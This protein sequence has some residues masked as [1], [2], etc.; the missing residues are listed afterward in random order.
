MTS[1]SSARTRRRVHV[2]HDRGGLLRSQP[3][4]LRSSSPTSPARAIAKFFGVWNCSQ[5]R[6]WAKA[7]TCSVS[8][9]TED[10]DFPTDGEPVF[11][12]PILIEAGRARVARA[13]RC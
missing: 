6:S 5:L 10:N 12:G 1:P 3:L 8:S 2:L 13:D 9:A 7:R 4:Q 11:L